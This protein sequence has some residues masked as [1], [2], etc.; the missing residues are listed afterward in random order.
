MDEFPKR[1]AC[2]SRDQIQIE[3]CQAARLVIVSWMGP[4]SSPLLRT[5]SSR[6][7]QTALVSSGSLC[8]F[9]KYI[10][11]SLTLGKGSRVTKVIF[12][13]VAKENNVFSK[14]KKKVVYFI[15]AGESGIV[16]NKEIKCYVPW[17]REINIC[18]L[19]KPS[20]FTTYAYKVFVHNS[21]GFTPSPEV[22]VTTLAGVPHR[23]TNVSV[24]VL[25]HTA[26]DVR[27]D[28]PSKEASPVFIYLYPS[29]PKTNWNRMC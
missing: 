6:R 5:A 24:I 29:P 12:F 22:T 13:G 4:W 11:I 14:G 28:K 20:R 23:G 10:C 19:K 17:K 16:R 27:W 18:L 21:V 26:V 25:N 7:W 15:G 9:K 8:L 1:R 3:S 2:D